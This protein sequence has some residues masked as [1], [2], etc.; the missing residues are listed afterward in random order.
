MMIRYDK[1][2]CWFIKGV[3]GM[4]QSSFMNEQHR[5]NELLEKGAITQ[6]E[7]EEQKQ[8]ILNELTEPVQEEIHNDPNI[9]PL[10]KK[11]PVGFLLR[12]G[13]LFLP[14]IFVWYLLGKGYSIFARVVGF[15]YMIIYIIFAPYVFFAIFLIILFS[16]M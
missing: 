8:R 9:L 7:Y 12:I 2:V 11:R 1:H 16:F 14:I 15:A 3:Y 5:L 13:I 10:N 4:D 6:K